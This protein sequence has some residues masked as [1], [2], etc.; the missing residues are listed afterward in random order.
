MMIPD[1]RPADGTTPVEPRKHLGDFSQ[2]MRETPTPSR[3]LNVHEVAALLGC[4]WRS[5]YRFSDAGRIPRGCKIGSL[6]KWNS[7]ELDEFIRGG[8]KLP[9][10]NAKGAR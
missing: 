9:R 8:C 7:S 6:R 5:V 1:T 3:L 2:A 10:A 4:S